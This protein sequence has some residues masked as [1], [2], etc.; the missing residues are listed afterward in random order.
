MSSVTAACFA[1]FVAV[2]SAKRTGVLWH[3]VEFSY[4]AVVKVRSNHWRSEVRG[5]IASHVD[6]SWLMD[7]RITW[8][9]IAIRN[10]DDDLPASFVYSEPDC[11]S[12]AE[13]RCAL[14]LRAGI[15][16]RHGVG[17]RAVGTRTRWTVVVC[18]TQVEIKSVTVG[19]SDRGIEHPPSRP[20]EEVEVEGEVFERSAVGAFQSQDRTAVCIATLT[21]RVRDRADST[22][23]AFFTGR[24]Q[25]DREQRVCRKR[26]D[27]TEN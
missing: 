21:H 20:A 22:F 2:L 24:L 3:P 27:E 4:A 26:F 23:E 14:S 19:R 5:S 13:R 7:G 6:Y 17:F 8:A 1:R 11:L 9:V 16:A 10:L 18:R 25:T 15:H 12:K